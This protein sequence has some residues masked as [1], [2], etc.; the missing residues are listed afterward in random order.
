MA[1]NAA[2]GRPFAPGQSGNPK[3]RLPG[4]RSHISVILSKL[5]DA[6]AKAILTAV[7]AAAAQGDMA[8]ARMV[9]DRC[10]PALKDRPLSMTLPDTGTPAGIE[11]AACAVLAACAR[12]DLLLSEGVVLSQLIEGRRKAAETVRL[13]QLAE[14]VAALEKKVESK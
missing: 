10:L 2:R 13:D 1:T 8:A 7:L 6:D 11:A 5:I 3:G 4:T 9:L 14:L 12:G